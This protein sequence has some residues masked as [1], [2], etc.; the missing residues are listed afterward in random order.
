MDL[1]LMGEVYYKTGKKD[2]ISKFIVEKIFYNYHIA[3]EHFY[4]KFLQHP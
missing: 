3:S 2:D 1:A 4:K